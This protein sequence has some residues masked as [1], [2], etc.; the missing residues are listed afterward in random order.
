[1]TALTK[2]DFF[3]QIEH[4]V[5]LFVGLLSLVA[6]LAIGTNEFGYSITKDFSEI[7]LVSKFRI[8]HLLLFI[9]FIMLSIKK[10]H[11]IFTKLTKHLRD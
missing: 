9:I 3:T 11:L 1:M 8:C 4:V 2:Q 10:S 7:Y 6:F 5:N